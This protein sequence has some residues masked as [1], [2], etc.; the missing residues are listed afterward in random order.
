MGTLTS[1]CLRKDC[2]HQW[3][4]HTGGAQPGGWA[5]YEPDWAN[6]S[7]SC[8]TPDCECHARI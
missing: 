1:L 3:A 7:G 6:A 4:V 8:Q 2:G 5:I